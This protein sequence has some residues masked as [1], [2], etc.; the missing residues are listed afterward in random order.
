M[1]IIQSRQN[2]LVKACIKLANS[3]R[4]R[5]KSGKS[6]LDG[7]HL[8][9]AALGAGVDID[10]LLVAVSAVEKPEIKQL[11]MQYPDKLVM[12]DDVLFAEVSEL[13]SLSGAVALWTLPSKPVPVNRGLVLV[14]DGVQDPGNVG[15]ILRTAAAVGVAQVWLSE[16]C[17]DAWSPKVLRAGMGAHFLLP[18]LER[19]PVVE[20]LSNF[21]GAKAVTTLE[22]SVSLYQADLRADLALVMGSEGQGISPEVLAL[23]DLRLRIPMHAGLESLNVGAATAICLYERLRQMGG[24]FAQTDITQ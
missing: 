15:A 16:Q 12:V 4:E 10:K 11:V 9:N 24:E 6:L 2:A 19:A 13:T 8:I 23:A 1:D 5:L 22:A 18:I 20:W 7:V 17:A 3:R 21:I 14:L